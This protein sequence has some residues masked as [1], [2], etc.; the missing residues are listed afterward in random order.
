MTQGK[1]APVFVNSRS[2]T[3]RLMVSLGD[4]VFDVYMHHSSVS[5][6]V[7]G[8]D[9]IRSGSRRDVRCLYKCDGARH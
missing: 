1:R 7:G 6:D 2:F 3:E 4:L 9:S 5:S 8:G